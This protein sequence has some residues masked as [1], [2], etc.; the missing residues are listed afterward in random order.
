MAIAFIDNDSS[1]GSEHSKLKNF[2]KG[3]TVPS[4][5]KNICDLWEEVQISLLGVWRKLIPTLIDDLEGFQTSVDKVT[6]ITG[7]N[8][9][10]RIRSGTQRYDWIAAISW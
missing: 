4:A 8:K 2:W 6:A 1:D 5:I 3:F 10:T 7:N 9:R